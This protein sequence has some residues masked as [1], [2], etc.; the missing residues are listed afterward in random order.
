MPG[1]GEGGGDSAD[2]GAGQGCARQGGAGQ[3]SAGQGGAGQGGAGQGGAGQELDVGSPGK[4]ERWLDRKEAY[5]CYLL[6]SGA[7]AQPDNFQAAVLLQSIG[8]EARKIYRFC[9][10]GR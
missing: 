9:V 1:D 4:R 2:G 6:L 10:L 5:E 8:P 3:G 7:N